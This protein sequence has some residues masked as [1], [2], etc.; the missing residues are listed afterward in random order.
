MNRYQK[1]FE[2][3][4]NKNESACIPF[5]VAGDPDID[6]S[7]EVFKAYI[8]GGADILEIGYPFSDPVA[9]AL[10]ISGLLKELLLPDLTMQGFSL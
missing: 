7:L 5:A 3:L 6:K 9:D 8:D 1:T 2:Q 4:K 10:S